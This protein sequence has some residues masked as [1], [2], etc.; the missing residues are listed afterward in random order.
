[1]AE[2]GRLRAARSA[3]ALYKRAL[4]ATVAVIQQSPAVASVDGRWELT[5]QERASVNNRLESCL[6][7]LEEDDEPAAGSNGAPGGGADGGGSDTLTD[8]DGDDP[9]DLLE[10]VQ[11]EVLGVLAAVGRRGAALEEA[12]K[13]AEQASVQADAAHGRQT[14]ELCAAGQRAAHLRSQVEELG[15]RLQRAEMRGADPSAVPPLDEASSIL[16]RVWANGTAWVL[17]EYCV[18]DGDGEAAVGWFMESSVRRALEDGAARGT[19]VAAGSSGSVGAERD[20]L[21]ALLRGGGAGA[22]PPIVLEDVAA[23]GRAVGELQDKVREGE[24]ELARQQ[25]EFRQYK[26]RAHSVLRGKA[27]GE[28]PLAAE[29]KRRA[30]AE[31]AA[32]AAEAAAAAATERSG[33]TRPSFSVSLG[34]MFVWCCCVCSRVVTLFCCV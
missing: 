6:S 24:R 15:E 17:I 19:T 1:M 18:G 29:V 33:R 5:A 20:G 21:A 4:C 31:A 30:D 28:D 10:R 34:L 16:W 9:C 7:A 12:R 2:S 14:D 26:I 32:V 11:R 25:E 27:G 22:T 3:G 23:L 13:C 8:A